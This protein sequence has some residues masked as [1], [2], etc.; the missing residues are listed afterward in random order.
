MKKSYSSLLYPT[1]IL[2]L[3][4]SIGT[5]AQAAG[6]AVDAGSILRQTEKE[7][8][9]PKAARPREKSKPAPTPATNSVETTVRVEKFIFVGNSL[10]SAEVL[11]SALSSFVDRSLNLNQLR[12][13]VDVITNTYRD[14]G[15]T[16]KAFLP[17]QEISSGA[18]TIQIVES[19]FGGA[20]VQGV[21][22]KRIDASR[23]VEMAEANLAK[24]KPMHSSDIDRTLLL[25][26]DLTGV[27]V[28]GNLVEGQ[29]DGETDLVISAVDESLL[30]GNA[31]LDNQGARATGIERLSA[32][33]NLNSP[34]GF[35][36]LFSTNLLQT[37]GTTYARGSYALP[38]GNNGLRAGLHASSLRYA[39]LTSYDANAN[40]TRGTADT[41][42]LDISY[43]LLRSQLN[44]VNLVWSYDH[45]SL[46]NYVADAL[47]SNYKIKVSGLSLNSNHIDNWGG[48]GSTS[49]SLSVT[50]GR[51][52]NDGSPNQQND[53]DGAHVAGSYRKINFYLNRL[54]SITSDLS[55]FAAFSAQAANKNLDSS[56]RMYLGGATGVRAFP[57]SEAGGAEGR[58]VTLELRQRLD[59]AYTLAGFY[60]YGHVTVNKFNANVSN[61]AEISAINAYALQGYGLSLA[62]QS[63]NSIELKGA[64][65]KRNGPNPAAD[66]TTG[67]DSDKTKKITRLWVSAGFAF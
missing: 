22:P 60:D 3:V 23:L 13:A 19:V 63:A 52:N 66:S 11:N 34:A 7:L 51:L 32:N 49:T 42:G 36:D 38:F 59:Y 14:A 53:A 8:N 54:Q 67:M 20:S 44:N 1:V 4:V 15:W 47:N 35:G 62:W 56:E 65:A 25:L 64:L 31:S 58:I 27:S 55:F 45:K 2:G 17:K 5:S 57:A 37:R 24:G 29:R 9:A 26:D 50:H 16:A 21:M 30:T 48:G 6:S 33:V 28:A 39:V 12:E 18:V 46:E 41:S 10:L 40:G 61:G 43:P